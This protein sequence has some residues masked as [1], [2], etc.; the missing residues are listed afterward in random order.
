MPTP[1]HDL[2]IVGGGIVGLAAA[3][4]A[5]L[6]FGRRVI[7]LEA[8]EGLARHQSG[9]NSGIVHSGLYY[10][11]GSLKARLCVEGREALYRFCHDRGI[12]CRRCGKLVLATREAERPRLEELERRGRA[13]GLVGVERLS[14]AGAREREPAAAGVAGLWVPQTGVVDFRQVAAAFAAEVVELGGEVVTRARVGALRASAGG[15]DIPT[16]ARRLRAGAQG[17]GA[18]RESARGARKGGAPPHG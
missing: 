3:R 15:G 12:P 14:A 17:H 8:E 13:N 16:P 5:A 9:R 2:A 11:P 6:R 4:E 18:G 7:V 1:D 10:E